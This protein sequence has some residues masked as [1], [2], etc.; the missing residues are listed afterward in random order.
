MAGIP[1]RVTVDDKQNITGSD[2]VVIVVREGNELRILLILC[3]LTQFPFLQVDFTTGNIAELNP[4]VFVVAVVTDLV[5][6]NQ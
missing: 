4:I 5:D 2:L 6:D 3:D 1:I